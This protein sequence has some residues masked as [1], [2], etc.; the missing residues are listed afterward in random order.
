MIC[1]LRTRISKPAYVHFGQTFSLINSSLHIPRYLVMED[2]LT[3]LSTPQSPWIFPH[4]GC[5]WLRCRTHT[6]KHTPLRSVWLWP[7]QPYPSVSS[8]S[9]CSCDVEEEAT[10]AWLMQNSTSGLTHP[11][12]RGC[13][14][15]SWGMNFL[16]QDRIPGDAVTPCSLHRRECL[17]TLQPP[18]PLP[19]SSSFL[20]STSPCFHVLFQLRWEE[21]CCS[22]HFPYVLVKHGWDGDVNLSVCACSHVSYSKLFKHSYAHILVW[23]SELPPHTSVSLPGKQKFWYESTM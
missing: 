16:L 10:A 17:V 11:K 15:H 22:L 9:M 12:Y 3:T 21:V 7:Y 23:W 4:L 2:C 14:V 6:E 13:W 1:S 8:L 20:R 5:L 18:S 19:S